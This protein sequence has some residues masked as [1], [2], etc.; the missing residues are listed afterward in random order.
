MLFPV[1][2]AGFLVLSSH[3]ANWDP[4]LGSPA[5]TSVALHL[6]SATHAAL[7]SSPF[8][9]TLALAACRLATPGPLL[10]PQVPGARELWRHSCPACD[11]ACFLQGALPCK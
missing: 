2:P 4:A 7:P 8:P 10:A 3:M 1:S 6:T 5:L 11:G 9:A